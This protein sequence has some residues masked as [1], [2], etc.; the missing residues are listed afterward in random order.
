MKHCNLDDLPR[1][2]S[3]GALGD[4]GALL[5]LAHLGCAFDN[6]NV[7]TPRLGAFIIFTGTREG[8]TKYLLIEFSK[9]AAKGDTAVGAEIL[10]E[11]RKRFLQAVGCFIYDKSTLFLGDLGEAFFSVLARHGKKAFEGKAS[12]RETRKCK[13]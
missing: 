13:S 12:C 4:I 11:F 5:F 8:E 6:E 1:N 9:L 10:D 7:F 2:K 3:G